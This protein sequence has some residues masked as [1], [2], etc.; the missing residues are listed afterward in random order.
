MLRR[1]A[2]F[3]WPEQCENAF[4]LLKAK[5]AKMPALQ[6]PNPNK[7][8]KLFTDASKQLLWNSP[9][10]E[11]KPSNFG[12]PHKKNAMQSTDQFINLLSI[13]QVPTV[14]CIVTTNL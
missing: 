4:N 10:R 7:H 3:K 9:P 5:L 1:G 14:H 11:K 12:P 2:A 6:Y 13:L 8:F